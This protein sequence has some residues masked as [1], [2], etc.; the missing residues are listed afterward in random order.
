MASTAVG[1]ADRGRRDGAKGLPYRTPNF[2]LLGDLVGAIRG[3]DL[4]TKVGRR[5]IRVLI[6][7]AQ[8][9]LAWVLR[10]VANYTSRTA[11]PGSI[12]SAEAPLT[13]SSYPLPGRRC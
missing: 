6:N 11:H 10:G 1:N 3:V 7:D 12:R 8:R 4:M 2:T 13:D 5:P 9:S